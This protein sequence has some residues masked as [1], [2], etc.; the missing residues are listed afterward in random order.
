VA[1]VHQ[2][3][4]VSD[5]GAGERPVLPPRA[6]T[7]LLDLAAH[8]LGSLDEAETPA[9]LGRVRLF[10][11]ARRARAGAGPLTVAL[12]RDPAFRARVAVA[13]RSMH[14]ELAA[15]LDGGAGTAEGSGP[16]PGSA[17]GSGPAPG[18]AEGS[19][20]AP[21]SAD[22]A[23]LLVGLVLLRPD[24]WV[25]ASA[26]VAEEME[27]SD[28]DR[29]RRD[30]EESAAARLRGLEREIEKLRAELAAA[31]AESASAADEL[32]AA[33][34]EL[35]R[36]RADADRARAA[37][38]VA[39]LE[40]EAQRARA[41]EA[42]TRAAQE[43]ERERDRGRAA[44]ERAEQALRAGREGRSLADARVRLLLDT[45]VEAATGL[46]RELAL[47]PLDL[48]PADLVPAVQAQAGAG[49]AG[50]PGEP[51]PATLAA[52]L[53]LPQAH[54]VVDGYNVTKTAFGELPL[55]EQRRRLVESLGA[56]AARTGAEITCVFDGA[57]VAARPTARVR[58]VRV[59]FSEAGT[60]ADDLVRRLV[61]AEPAGR[62]VVVVSSDNE[63]A[64]G[65]RAL[66]ARAL[67]ATALVRLLGRG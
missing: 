56:L 63:V 52:L 57:D 49:T 46:R 65:V 4:D 36:L 40:G 39:Q 8:V 43:V 34:R 13:W 38:R 20:P 6:Q 41:D 64:G 2:E 60:T 67:P 51:D 1:T 14:P 19:G 18:S 45:V 29:L 7:A 25:D 23:E 42:V 9:A 35:R 27:R 32:V 3:D 44:A 50:A 31:R 21:G 59:L 28:A 17:E 15:V 12:E 54:L 55:V 58:G 30:L 47:P 24:G 26:R 16:A 22:G 48:R 66:G 10:A 33:R 5:E 61:R 53:A 37:A 11:P 62:V